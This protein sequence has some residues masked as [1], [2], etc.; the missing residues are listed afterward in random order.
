MANTY[1]LNGK[2]YEL[3]NNNWFEKGGFVRLPKAVEMDLDRRYPS[4]KSPKKSQPKGATR[5][6]RRQT[7]QRRSRKA[8][9][10][11]PHRAKQE[12]LINELLENDE[13]IF[14][15][16]TR[17]VIPPG[18]INTYR[19]FLK[20]LDE[21]FTQD[22][23]AAATRGS[24]RESLQGVLMAF[25]KRIGESPDLRVQSLRPRNALFF[26]RRRRDSKTLYRI[27]H[28]VV[29]ILASF[30]EF[31][32]FII[33]DNRSWLAKEFGSV[34]WENSSAVYKQQMQY[35]GFWDRIQASRKSQE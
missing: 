18:Q 27:R 26:E 11:S 12:I 4:A 22:Q 28:R 24:N 5:T 1:Q 13:T 21:F 10:R 32:D 15:I 34:H 16:L 17:L 31:Y 7:S 19:F 35:F 30:P 9:V 20:N 2:E 14:D 23:F 29:E 3:R 25:G 6:G 8:P 33:N